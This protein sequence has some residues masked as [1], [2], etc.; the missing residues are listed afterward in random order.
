[1]SHSRE[2]F[3]TLEDQITLEGVAAHKS[4]N[5]DASAGKVGATVWAFKD[6]VGNL[7]HPQLN[8]EGAVVVSSEG[9]GIPKQATSGGEVAGSLTLTTICEV[10]LTAAKTHGKISANG[11]C[12]KETIFYVI[13]QDDVANTILASFIV[14]PGHYS[15]ECNLGTTEIISGATGTQKLLLR[16]KNFIKASDFLGNISCLEFAA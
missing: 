12:F 6:S 11:S 4:E 9:A 16:A 3:P 14:G 13:Q 5:G 2:S 1:M 7:V 10:A 15:F 8:T